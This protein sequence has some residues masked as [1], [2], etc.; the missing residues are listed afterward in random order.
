MAFKATEDRYGARQ[1]RPR[2]DEEPVVRRRTPRIEGVT[3]VDINDHEFL[4]Q[5]ITEHGKIVPSRLT[6]VPAALQRQIKHGIR[7]CRVM[8]LLP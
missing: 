1:Q 3:E 6:G 2:R 8:G 5:F 7:R 4:R